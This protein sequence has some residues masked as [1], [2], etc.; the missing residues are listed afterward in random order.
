MSKIDFEA[1]C[2]YL[3][4]RHDEILRGRRR[5]A[6][7]P[8]SE[9]SRTTI[10]EDGDGVVATRRRDRR[11]DRALSLIGRLENGLGAVAPDMAKVTFIDSSGL[12]A[13]AIANRAR[14]ALRL[15]H[16]G[17]RHAPRA[18]GTGRLPE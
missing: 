10:H 15:D 11:R 9:D 12:K 7:M 3:V 18:G 14:D 4:V 5:R 16:V 17:Q 2:G 6:S 1:L 13:R 8:S